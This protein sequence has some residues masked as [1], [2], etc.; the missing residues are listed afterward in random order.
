MSARLAL[1]WRAMTSRLL[2]DAPL[3]SPLPC[4]PSIYVAV[5]LGQRLQRNGRNQSRMVKQIRAN[6]IL[7]IHFDPSISSRSNAVYI[8]SSSKPCLSRIVAEHEHAARSVAEQN[9][10]EA[11]LGDTCGLVQGSKSGARRCFM[12]E[13]EGC[14][15]VKLGESRGQCDLCRARV[16]Y[17][18]R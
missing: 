13:T 10:L 15:W 5:N 4:G 3:C 17:M 2:L 18:H 16:C 14:L 9:V 1:F 11:G 6:S 12:Y 7:C 8:P